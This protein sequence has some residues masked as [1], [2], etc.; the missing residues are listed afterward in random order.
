MVNMELKRAKESNSSDLVKDLQTRAED[1]E[2]KMNFLKPKL[3]VLAGKQKIYSPSDYL[4]VSSKSEYIIGQESAKELNITSLND[5][6]SSSFTL[7][8]MGCT[9]KNRSSVMDANHTKSI[10]WIDIN[11]SSSEQ[12]Q[13]VLDRAGVIKDKRVYIYCKDSLH[14]SIYMLFALKSVGYEDIKIITNSVDKNSS[15]SSKSKS[16]VD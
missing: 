6:N 9:D 8:D 5:V 16:L 2:E 12:I 15:L 11:N 1:I 10:S 14:Q 3:L 7:I 4:V 13:K